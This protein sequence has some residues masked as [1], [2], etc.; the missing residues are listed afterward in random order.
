[1]P[2]CFP[3][4]VCSPRHIAQDTEDKGASITRN[5]VEVEVP[6]SPAPTVHDY[7]VCWHVMK[8]FLLWNFYWGVCI[9]A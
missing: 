9:R 3:L 6:A 8:K 4:L 2:L 7:T 1:M 5:V